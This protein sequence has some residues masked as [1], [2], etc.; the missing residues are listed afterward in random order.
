VAPGRLALAA[1]TGVALLTSAGC[2]SSGNGWHEFAKRTV[3]GSAVGAAG[4]MVDNPAAVQVKVEADPDVKTQVNYSIDCSGGLH[5]QTGLAN[6][7]TPFTTPV[8]LP[9]GRQPCT[10]SASA[11]KSR[12]TKMTVTLLARSSSST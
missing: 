2:G 6:G 7:H 4:G 9:G 12:P 11:S 1:L 3:D 10:V 5:P 8:P